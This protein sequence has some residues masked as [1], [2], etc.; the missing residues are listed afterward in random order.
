[1][2]HVRFM[3][4]LLAVALLA[5]L[6]P[7]ALADVHEHS[8]TESGR[9]QPTCTRQGSVTYTCRC[10]ETRTESISALGH[11]WGRWK[12]TKEATCTKRGT[13]T[14]KCSRCGETET[15]KSDYAP[16]EWGE[17]TVTKEATCVE[18][19][20]REHTC[21]VCG[22]TVSETIKMTAHTWGEWEIVVE[23]TDHSAGT[24]RHVCQVCG[25]EETEDFDPE[26]TLRRG[27]RGD[28]VRQLQE[29]LICY[30]AMS[31]RADGVYGKGTER[32]VRA[33]QEAEGLE[34]DGVAWPQTRAFA[35][36]LFG[37]WRTVA[38]LTRFSDGVRERVCERCGFVD[39][40]VTQAWPLLRRGDKG[41]VVEFIQNVITEIGYKPGRPDGRYGPKLDAA[42]EGWSRD[43][44]WYYEPG[45]IKPIVIDRIIGEWERKDRVYPCDEESPVQIA[46][47]LTPAFD[48][49]N[50]YTGQTLKYYW[51]AVNN[52]TEDCTLGPIM[53]SFGKGN[54][55][56]DV[57]TLFRYVGDINGDILKAGGANTLTGSFSVVAEHD[58]FDWADSGVGE[59]FLNAWAIGTSKETGRKWRSP[60]E[61]DRVSIDNASD[62]VLVAE[63]LSPVKAAYGID[64]EVTFR[65]TLINRGSEPCTVEY[66]DVTEPSDQGFQVNDGGDVLEP[67]GGSISDTC[68]VRLYE[69]WRYKGVQ[70]FY[71]GQ[72]W[73]YFEGWATRDGKYVRATPFNVHL[74]FDEAA[75]DIELSV[76]QTSPRQASYAVG[77]QVT[78]EWTLKNVSEQEMRLD[79]VAVRTI[80]DSIGDAR[81]EVLFTDPVLLL[82]NGEEP[83][84]GTCTITLDEDW[85]YHGWL[86]GYDGGWRL[87][88]YAYAFPNATQ[89]P[90]FV[91]SNDARVFLP[92][93]EAGLLLTVNQIS[94]QKDQYAVGEEIV[95]SWTLT[96]LGEEDLTLDFVAMEYGDEGFPSV[97]DEPDRLLANGANTLTGVWPCTL[98][99][100]M[101]LDD[102]WHFRFFARGYTDEMADKEKYIPS[103]AVEFEYL[104]V[105]IKPNNLPVDAGSI[106]LMNG[107]VP[108]PPAGA[109]GGETVGTVGIRSLVVVEQTKKDDDYYDGAVIPVKMRLTID[110]LDEYDLLG[111]DVAPGDS[112]SDEPWMHGTLLPGESYDFTYT[113]V[114][115]TKQ[116]GWT[117]RAVR[118]WL[119]S[120]GTGMRE[121]EECEVRP[122][123]T[124]PT[125]TLVGGSDNIINDNAA[126]L[127]LKIKAAFDDAA[128]PFEYMDIPLNIDSDGNTEIYDVKLV[129]EQK[130]DGKVYHK[131]TFDIVKKMSAGSSMDIVQKVFV[132]KDPGEELS[133][134]YWF[135]MYL[136]G[137][138]YDRKGRPQTVESLPIAPVF[139]MLIPGQTTR[140]DMGYTIE[141][142]KPFYSLNDLVT[143]E[144][145][146]RNSGTESVQD[147]EVGLDPAY[148]YRMEAVGDSQP[149]NNGA[150]IAPKD[151]GTATFKYRIRPEDLADGG[152]EAEFIATCV[153]EETGARVRSPRALVT[154]PV[155][156]EEADDRITLSA[157]IRLPRNEYLTGVGIP[158]RLTIENQ[159]DL[160]ISKVR[161]CATGDNRNDYL[162]MNA[163][164][165]D[166]G[167]G[168]KG[169][170]CATGGEIPA[171]S[172]DTIDVEVSIPSEFRPYGRF[173][174][175]WT[176]EVEM[177]DGTLVRTD[178]AGLSL[179]IVQETLE[180]EA[181]LSDPSIEVYEPD[182][183]ANVFVKLK[184]TGDY[185]PH[186]YTIWARQPKF[187][188]S[189]SVKTTNV[190][191]DTA[192]G[193]IPLP[194]EADK[195]VDGG[196]R[197]IL[198]TGAVRTGTLSSNTVELFIPAEEEPG[199]PLGDIELTV[200]QLNESGNPEGWWLNGDK[201]KVHVYAVYT[202]EGTPKHMEIEMVD[203]SESEVPLWSTDI[204]NALTL[205]DEKEITL[206]S[207]RA[208]DGMCTYVFTASAAVE[209][210]EVFD[211]HSEPTILVFDMA[212][213]AGGPDDM[214]G[215]GPG[216]APETQAN[217]AAIEDFKE[218]VGL[219]QDSGDAKG[220][221]PEPATDDGDAKE[222]EPVTA[223]VGGEAAATEADGNG[224]A[225]DVNLLGED[226]KAAEAVDVATG[227][228][229]D[230]SS[231]QPDAALGAF[232][233]FWTADK[234]LRDDE[235]VDA[236]PV[237]GD[238]F[239]ARIEGVRI[240]LDGYLFSEREIEAELADG[241]LH[242]A[243]P[244]DD[245][246]A[247]LD[248][249]VRHIEDDAL[250]MTLM[251]EGEADEVFTFI[252]GEA[253]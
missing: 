65:W 3:A 222:A 124:Y 117:P 183:E 166:F 143:I 178:M 252:R 51:T 135:R 249:A 219:D 23:A 11:K 63:L 205:E 88:F 190:D 2:K 48:V 112:V 191:G 209:D 128:F 146:V 187:S 198:Q 199:A 58:R 32:S 160:K 188:A 25:A 10:G 72:W 83:A 50:V 38:K 134:S 169:P 53:Y 106:S 149:V 109:L 196:W 17:W 19:G 86:A 116:T 185:P 245:D 121:T 26:G 120:H 233:G 13:E 90:D 192:W 103:N 27:D 129:C 182:S 174:A 230:L 167:H 194:L 107:P 127:Y 57:H 14:R 213:G 71:Y 202:G 76:K 154:L 45:L 8:W 161:V 251:R 78:F 231:V 164:W 1:M 138:Y 85:I 60:T 201:V 114:L 145:R 163:P 176:A 55:S 180:M 237:V 248:L 224:S 89:D 204:Y 100:D 95:Y 171:F 150:A 115:D 200:S 223:P 141:P 189:I 87:C 227:E 132:R 242:Y 212:P 123:F 144:F 214:P 52:G 172:W 217:W 216:G 177:E 98:D 54:T 148:E 130:R 64:D 193:I 68:T 158:C 113:M 131:D 139:K 244:G 159:T 147:V 34:T 15:R 79:Y 210:A 105:K 70:E 21:A 108:T 66:V 31:G 111:I 91:R 22:K 197:F 181:N 195:M 97:Y 232:D 81:D 69:D 9:T 207:K 165:H 221:E 7:T 82:P 94:A 35:Q 246:L 102:A 241:A 4:I 16:H 118:A 151:M 44:G 133:A 28:D 6:M 80:P 18:T 36:H 41:K 229:I 75:S 84:S 239:T 49:N 250:E 30:G 206:D 170:E 152:F 93:E 119:N 253:E 136:T 40:E 234:V 77:D 137:T 61:T 46:L 62:L 110:D 33:V 162:L 240:A 235:L 67:N 168:L 59:M 74:P 156:Q 211:C 203:G 126:W 157:A 39:R 142:K 5:G 12:T 56:E 215:E 96:N 186:E 226:G 92:G 225:T 101:L 153:G 155:A 175:G 140:L 238:V 228:G 236:A 247:G 125:V 184:Y 122:P 20:S 220:A 37:E 42:I 179:P 29:G 99:G 73:F 24:R 243:F 218:K 173:L 47:K 43:H 208:V 104:P